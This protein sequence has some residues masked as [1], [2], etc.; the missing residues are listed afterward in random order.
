MLNVLPIKKILIMKP[1][2]EKTKLNVK[3]LSKEELQNIYGGSWWE[4][5]YEKG[6]IFWIF[7]PYDD[8]YPK[9]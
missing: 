6:K 8:D 7:H 9:E 5:R 4:V 2:I 3:E 1:V